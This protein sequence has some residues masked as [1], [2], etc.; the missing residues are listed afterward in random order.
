M[1]S[2]SST[3]EAVAQTVDRLPAP[4]KTTLAL[5]HAA[6]DDLV[7]LTLATLPLGSRTTLSVLEVINLADSSAPDAPVIVSLSD[8]GRDVITAC[9]LDGVPETVSLQVTAL[10]QARAQRAASKTTCD[11]VQL[12][13]T[14]A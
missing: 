7:E 8:F 6:D 13:A 9:A 14:Q 2:H 4:L 5:L 1:P 10:E 3:T 12:V 11:G